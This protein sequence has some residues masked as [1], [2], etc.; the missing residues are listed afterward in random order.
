VRILWRYLT[1]GFLLTFA[2]A[3][4]VLT[5][6]LSLAVLFRISDWLAFGAGW[7]AILRI[8]LTGVPSALGFAIPVSALFSILLLFGRL[9]ADGEITAMK[10]SGISLREIIVAPLLVALALSAACLYLNAEL[11]P[12]TYHARRQALWS[13]GLETPIKMIEPG[14]FIRDFPGLTIYIGQKKDNRLSDIII[15][16]QIGKRRQRSIRARTGFVRTDPRQGVLWLDLRDVRV[17]PFH[18]DR[19]GVGH[20][21]EFPVRIDVPLGQ[22]DAPKKKSDF[23]L[24]EL[25][26]RIR[27]A[28]GFFPE[29]DAESLSR[30]RTALLVEASKRVALS[31]SCFAFALLGIPLANRTRRRESSIGIAISLGVVFVFYLFIIVAESLAKY[32]ALQPHAIALLPVLLAVGAGEYLIRRSE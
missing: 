31:I 23:T 19:P 16:Q 30:Q 32:P 15:Y 22:S 3:L 1:S 27:D 14:R 9:S 21:N 29:L 24:A 26:A 11:I 25:C 20:F 12:S 13:L 7:S 18:D 2:A 6:I 10:S 8:F 28:R 17:D 5:F 4:A